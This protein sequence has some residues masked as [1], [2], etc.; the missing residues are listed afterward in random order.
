MFQ[1]IHFYSMNLLYTK[2]RLYSSTNYVQ[3]VIADLLSMLFKQQST[4]IMA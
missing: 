1:Y 3:Q 4:I 2:Q